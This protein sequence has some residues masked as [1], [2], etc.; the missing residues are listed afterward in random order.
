[1]FDILD[2]YSNCADQGGPEAVQEV[3]DDEVLGLVCHHPEDQVYKHNQSINQT[4]IRQGL[5]TQSN[6]HPEDQV[7]K[8]NQSTNQTSKRQGLQTQSIKS[9]KHPEDHTSSITTYQSLPKMRS[10][11]HQRSH[12]N[13]QPRG[14]VETAGREGNTICFGF[15]QNVW[16]TVFKFD[17]LGQRHLRQIQR[18]A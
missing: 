18:G 6:K 15:L 3:H 1:M 11:P 9:I 12:R 4:S 8:H 17:I 16:I 13:A 10:C 5:Q 2:N 14:G 7:Y